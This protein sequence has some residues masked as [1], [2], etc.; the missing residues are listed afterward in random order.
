MLGTFCCLFAN[1]VSFFFFFLSNACPSL[2]THF[3]GLSVIKRHTLFYW[4]S[5]YCN[6]QSLSFY[7]LKVYINLVSQKSISSAFLTAAFAHFVSPC[8]IW[9]IPSIFQMF[10]LLLYMQWWSIISD[11]WCHYCS[12]FGLPQT[13]LIRDGECNQL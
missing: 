3:V 8:H 9:A 5:C 4:T 10:S 11:L 7:K 12:C 6:L 2:L 1:G 13:A